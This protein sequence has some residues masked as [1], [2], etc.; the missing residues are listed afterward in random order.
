MIINN[1]WLP[2]FLGL[3]LDQFEAPLNTA[4]LQKEARNPMN[5]HSHENNTNQYSKKVFNITIPGCNI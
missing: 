1:N 5:N 2:N 4:C 3:T